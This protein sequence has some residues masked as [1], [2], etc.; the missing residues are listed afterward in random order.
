MPVN[1]IR[2]SHLSLG[3]SVSRISLIR[4]SQFGVLPTSRLVQMMHINLFFL[5][6][7]CHDVYWS[8]ILDVLLGK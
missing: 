8:I 2:N 1:K 5:R 6:S 7:Y 4:L 3:G